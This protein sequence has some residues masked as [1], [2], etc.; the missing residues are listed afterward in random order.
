MPA[1]VRLIG[2]DHLVATQGVT[3]SSYE[4]F[5]SEATAMLRLPAHRSLVSCIGLL[6]C[7][8][9]GL[10]AGLLLEPVLLPAHFP[11]EDGKL[12]LEELLM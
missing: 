2:A 11:P 3:V 7:P 9:T 10:V 12:D 8:T 6:K 5:L 1:T 4:V